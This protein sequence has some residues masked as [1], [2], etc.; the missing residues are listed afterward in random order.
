[1]LSPLSDGQGDF[2]GCKD[3]YGCKEVNERQQLAALIQALSKLFPDECMV[4]VSSFNDVYFIK[5][6]SD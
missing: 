6:G 3:N 1:M 4:S 5:Y 2:S